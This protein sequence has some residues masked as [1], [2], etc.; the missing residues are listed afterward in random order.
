MADKDTHNEST[1]TRGNLVVN[2]S[3]FTGS[4]E[5]N[6]EVGKSMPKL[7]PNEYECAACGEIYE[8]DPDFDAQAEYEENFPTYAKNNE[9]VD[10]VCDDCYKQLTAWKSPEEAERELS[11][12]DTRSTQKPSRGKQKIAKGQPKEG[13]K[14]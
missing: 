8:L 10:I 9:P 11:Q 2:P 6:V 4:F 13:N 12:Q 14:L 5:L 7:K 3:E 1:K